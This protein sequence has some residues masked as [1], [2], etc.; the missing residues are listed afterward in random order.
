MAGSLISS[1]NS[2]GTYGAFNNGAS[3]TNPFA[4]LVNRFNQNSI[5]QNQP[6]A[7]QASVNDWEPFAGITG[8]S[9]QNK[10]SLPGQPQL[11]SVEQKITA[12]TSGNRELNKIL[13]SDELMNR[14]EAKLTGQSDYVVGSDEQG[15]NTVVDIDKAIKEK[16]K[17]LGVGNDDINQYLDY[18][19]LVFQSLAKTNR[20]GQG[21]VTA[22]NMINTLPEPLKNKIMGELQNRLNLSD[23]TVETAT[24][25]LNGDY[26]TKIA[27][28][29]ALGRSVASAIASV[30][31]DQSFTLPLR[32]HKEISDASK[33]LGKT[34]SWGALGANAAWA[35]PLALSKIGG[36]GAVATLAALGPIGWGTL[37]V[38]GLG[39][40]AYIATSEDARTNIANTWKA[41]TDYS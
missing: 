26:A 17:T 16:R 15:N 5:T 1:G 39:S 41:V 3:V 8:Q 12:M 28:N 24:T 38:A 34:L 36:G 6:P 22:L 23:D 37:G 14:Y 31:K 13:Q 10:P 25:L 29:P 11:P 9:S 21:A 40:L 30:A 2:G 33:T 27:Q 35:A 20:N 4:P 18:Q 7:P 32:D 19:K